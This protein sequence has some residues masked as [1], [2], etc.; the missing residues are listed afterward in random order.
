MLRNPTEERHHCCVAASLAR[1]PPSVKQMS[2]PGW[3][4]KETVDEGCFGTGWPSISASAFFACVNGKEG[5]EGK[6]KGGG[7]KQWV[8]WRRQ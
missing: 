3:R 1:A 8:R 6:K 5:G 7:G 2:E 4:C